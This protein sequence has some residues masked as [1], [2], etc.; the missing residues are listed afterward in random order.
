MRKEDGKTF[1]C[2]FSRTGLNNIPNMLL[3][4][5]LAYSSE[6]LTKAI[7]S[8]MQNPRNCVKQHKHYQL[9][10][11]SYNGD[12]IFK[13]GRAWNSLGKEVSTYAGDL[14]FNQKGNLE[15]YVNGLKGFGDKSTCTAHNFCCWG[16]RAGFTSTMCV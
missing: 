2:D 16:L 15:D 4:M 8:I 13:L 5:G 3:G 14:K 1:T 6:N 9:G 11:S 7:D 12:H 10:I